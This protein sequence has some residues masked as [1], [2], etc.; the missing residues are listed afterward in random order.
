MSIFAQ[1]MAARLDLERP[2]RERSS[3]L[4][5]IREFRTVSENAFCGDSASPSRT[6]LFQEMISFS[7]SL[8]AILP[9]RLTSS[10]LLVSPPAFRS[11]SATLPPFRS[12]LFSSL[13]LASP[14]RTALLSAISFSW[15]GTLPTSDSAL[16]CPRPMSILPRALCGR[17]SIFSRRFVALGGRSCQQSRSAREKLPTKHEIV[18][19]RRSVTECYA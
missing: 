19:L 14:T 1:M 10:L 4:V 12:Q 17:A 5:S 13:A 11:V 9:F 6:G 8:S 18:P 3:G 2:S 16:E 15:A 7:S